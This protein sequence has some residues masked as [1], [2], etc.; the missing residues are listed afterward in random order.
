MIDDLIDAL[1]APSDTIDQA[2]MYLDDAPDSPLSDMVRDLVLDLSHAEGA[3]QDLKVDNLL[4]PLRL[5]IN[6][7]GTFH[8]EGDSPEWLELFDATFGSA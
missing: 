5:R 2:L 6:A 3:L 4:Y 8:I 7:D 1:K